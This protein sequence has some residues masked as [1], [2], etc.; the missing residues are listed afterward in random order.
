M[1]N[2]QRFHQLCHQA[3]EAKDANRLH[4]TQKRLV[5]LLQEE[6]LEFLSQERRSRNDGFC[7]PSRSDEPS[8]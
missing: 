8:T 5:E 4:E 1:L 6:E 3:E 2:R 7:A